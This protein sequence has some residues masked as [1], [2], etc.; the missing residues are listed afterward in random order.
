MCMVDVSNTFE[1]ANPASPTYRDMLKG[2]LERRRARNESYSLRAFA[3]DI[4]LHSSDLSRVINGK[5]SLAV[6]TAVT[7][8]GTL[9]WP[10]SDK[11]A[12]LDSVVDEV[13]RRAW[14]E[15]GL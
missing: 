7:I 9:D 6:R 1:D 13:R 14:E 11:R 3:R 5:K 2:E 10:E 4:S 8:V 15:A 12:F